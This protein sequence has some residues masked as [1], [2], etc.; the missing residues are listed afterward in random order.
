MLKSVL[1][2][3]LPPA[4]TTVFSALLKSNPAAWGEPRF[5][6]VAVSERNFTW[7]TSVTEDEVV[8]MA[9]DRLCER[10]KMIGVKDFRNDLMDEDQKCKL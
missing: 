3:A 7:R 8:D 10:E 5:G 4:G 6:M 1:T 2:T 9:N